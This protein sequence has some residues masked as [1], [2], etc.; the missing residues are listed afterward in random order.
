MK[1]HQVREMESKDL[2]INLKD[3]FESLENLRFRHATGQLEN[4]KSIPNTKKEI[5]RIK[6]ILRE[7]KLNINEKLNIKNKK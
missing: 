4:Y 2:E 6:T 5:A 1:A 3:N 7:R